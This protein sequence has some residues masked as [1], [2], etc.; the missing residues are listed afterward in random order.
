MTKDKQKFDLKT[1][2]HSTAHLM[3]QAVKQLYP[4]TQVTI[5]PV[6]EDGFY[7]D[8]Y[9]ETPFV[10]EDLEKIELRMKEIAA[11]NLGIVRQELPRDD[12]LKLFDE[13]GEPFKRE[14][15]D[16]IDSGDAISVYTQGEFTDLCRGPHVDNTRVLKSFRLLHTSAAYW[17]G[18]ER[19]KV[20]Q[21]IYGTAWN[22][23]KELRVYL[24]RL[25][26]A[27]KRDH[28]KLGKELDLF[29]VT[30]EVG[31]GLIL[32]HPKGSRVRCIVEEFWKDEHFKNG[33]EMVYSPHA[34]RVDLWKTSG[35]MD[36]YKDNIF[37]P[38]DIEGREYVM[39][40]M[41]C[42]FHIQ[43]YKSRLRSYRDLPIRFAEL[44]T[45]Y[46]YERS[47]VLHGLLRVRGF[48]QDDAHL[49]CRPSQIEEEIVKV[50]DLI[51][52]ILKSF[53]FNEYK[54]YLSTRPDKFVGSEEGWEKA[55]SA[56]SQALEKSELDYE[57]DPGEGVF[58]GP[59]IDI[60]IK[61]SLNRFWQ[62]STV[63][64]DFNLPERFDINYVEEDG[65]RHRPIM[66]HR[67]LM[68]SLERFFGCLV[69]HY[70][71]A[72]PLWLAPTQA[73]LLPITDQHND[74][75]DEVF[76]QLTDKGFRVEKDLRN[77]KI[78]FKIREA[79]LQKIPY[80]IVLGDKEVESRS[81]AVRKRRSKE[82]RTI[83]LETFI[84]E[85]NVE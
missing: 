25:E 72:F 39:K 27:K 4:E 17:R 2:R 19:N 59:K 44:G 49:F 63:Q 55:T 36:F 81:L 77:E 30:D 32:W 68:G 57:V 13:L 50:L 35:H 6:I 56:L 62:V 53:G 82:T 51:L 21:R 31:P 85:L 46:R 3:A 18:D 34:A 33:Y 65:Q 69:E 64:V 42:P 26:E 54:V 75:V 43:I 40:P 10:P 45:V 16:E 22:T 7:Y 60:K 9:R 5:G 76:R 67:A 48:T 66:L 20:L 8:F 23:D 58:Y 79:Q 37:S 74:Y 83:N 1:I 71:G 11:G 14:V 24:K 38:M 61:D 47:G 80:M 28:R 29:S 70:A 78:G 73:V 15:I 52:F 41:N 12:A 84:E